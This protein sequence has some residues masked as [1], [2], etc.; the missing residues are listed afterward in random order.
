MKPAVGPSVPLSQ[1]I[2]SL[3]LARTY[4]AVVSP[5]SQCSNKRS[6]PDPIS[7]APACPRLLWA[8]YAAE[9]AA[10]SQ[11]ISALAPLLLTGNSSNTQLSNPIYS[12][13][14]DA[15]LVWIA[16]LK[17]NSGVYDED[18]NVVTTQILDP[19]FDTTYIR[20]QTYP[21]TP[22]VSKTT[23]RANGSFREMDN[24]EARILYNHQLADITN[25][26]VVIAGTASKIQFGFLQPQTKVNLDTC[27]VGT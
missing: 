21:F 22:G 15:T 20:C 13:D 2:P 23:Y 27:P 8:A 14:Q 3:S 1:S 4:L 26:P 16:T 6:S 24:L 19:D 5:C 11:D 7:G 10:A 18:G 25:D 17:D 12:D 9:L